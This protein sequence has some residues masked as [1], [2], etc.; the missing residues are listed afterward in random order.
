MESIQ[1]N[2]LN[3]DDNT[4]NYN[5]SNE[6]NRKTVDYS[7]LLKSLY[8]ENT[9]ITK[10][11]NYDTIKKYFQFMISNAW[12]TFFVGNHEITSY[13]IDYIQ[14]FFDQK[15]KLENVHFYNSQLLVIHD[16]LLKFY[17][18]VEFTP[19][20]SFIHKNNSSYIFVDLCWCIE[21]GMR[22]YVKQVPINTCVVSESEV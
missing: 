19:L 4:N 18:F 14:K 3:I 5:I 21:R 9:I 2:K 8:D 6:N 12:E 1:I 11:K 16:N 7:V 15:Q 17:R 22:I 20:E 13:D 10:F